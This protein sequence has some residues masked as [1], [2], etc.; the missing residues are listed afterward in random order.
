VVACV[1]RWVLVSFGCGSIVECAVLI[2]LL[3]G[4]VFPES[5]AALVLCCGQRKRPG[6]LSSTG[7]SWFRS[8]GET[9]SDYFAAI[10]RANKKRNAA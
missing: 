1:A 5:A 7:L 9:F 10:L 8:N 6:N 4:A 2:L 3:S